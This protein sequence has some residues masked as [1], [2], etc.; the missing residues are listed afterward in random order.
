MLSAKSAGL[1]ILLLSAGILTA[2][3]WPLWRGPANNGI[4]A[5]TGWK[6]SGIKKVLW[7]KNVGIGYSCMTVA[8]GKLYTLGNKDGKDIIICL[9]AGTGDEKWHY[10]YACSPGKSYPGP[11]ATPVIYKKCIYSLSSEGLLN[12]LDAAAG[13]L[14]WSKKVGGGGAKNL[15]WKY[16]GSPC[17]V[18]GKIII[19][20][21]KTGM[22]F[23]AA[24]GRELWKSGGT[25]GYATPIIFTSDGEKYAAIFSK[26]T[27][28]IVSVKDGR[29]AASYPWKTK[30]DIN[31]ADPLVIGDGM[32]FI[33][34]GYGHA[35]ALL[36]F[37]GGKLKKIWENQNMKSQFSSPVFYGEY[38]YGTDG[39][40]GKGNLLCLSVKDG[41]VK[42]KYE[43]NYYGSIIIAGEKIIFLTDRGKILIGKASPDGFKPET[44]DYVM[45]NAGKCWTMPV[46]ADGRLY[47][48][49][50][51]GKLV[52]FDMN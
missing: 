20:A 48:R 8:D 5:E 27:L 14:K 11:R 4:S 24:T 37:S 50:S 3:D 44:G 18:D 21:G 47:C 40:A 1:L 30:Y 41:S 45:K 38:I 2:G 36:K 42:W 10:S 23:D 17:P 29:S 13:K 28:E 25:G 51:N 9:D 34:S 15:R 12:C 35:G 31:A 7:E 26:D 22:A 32:I 33:T 6:P 19:N 49:G 52:C 46:L 16:S 39:K 43:K